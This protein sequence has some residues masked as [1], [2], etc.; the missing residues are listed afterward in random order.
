MSQFYR[1]LA[2]GRLGKADAL[3]EAQIGLIENPAFQHPFFWAPFTLIG[4]W[5]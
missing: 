1:L 3:R 4:E 2:V 5:Q